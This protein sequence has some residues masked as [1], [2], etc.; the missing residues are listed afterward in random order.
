MVAKQPAIPAHL[1]AFGAAFGFLADGA[2]QTA[3]P[4]KP[5]QLRRRGPPQRPFLVESHVAR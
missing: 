1:D 4:I 2:V 3:Q 5:L